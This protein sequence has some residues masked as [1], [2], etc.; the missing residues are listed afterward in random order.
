ME[1]KG[2]RVNTVALIIVVVFMVEITTKVFMSKVTFYP[3]AII[4]IARIVEAALMLLTVIVFG[5]GLS[6]IGLD[7]SGILF[8]VRRGFIWSAGFGIITI[9][10]GMVLLACKINP[11]NLLR[12]SLPDTTFKI[13]LLLLV[14]GIIGPVTEEIFFRGILYTFLRKW[15]IIVALVLSTIIFVILHTSPGFGIPYV[16]LVG[17]IF[18]AIAYEVERS[19]IVPIIIHV[20]GNL[21]LFSL[22][23]FAL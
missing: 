8:G 12:I 11:F 16:P 19:L 3:M 14:G 10:V 7:R 4:G 21:A 2:L 23:F 17:G 6:T 18:F 13:V 20:S 15:G 5:N 1:T 9:L 22:S